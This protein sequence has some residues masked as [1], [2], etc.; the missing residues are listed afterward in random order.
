MCSWLKCVSV[1]GS[2]V[3]ELE[4]N[5]NNGNGGCTD[6]EDEDGEEPAIEMAGDEEETASVTSDKDDSVIIP[7]HEK[8]PASPSVFSVTPSD[9][10]NWKLL[11][12]KERMQ[13][14]QLWDL[15]QVSII[16]RSQFYLMFR[17]DPA[18]QVYMEVELRRLAWLQ[19]QLNAENTANV[20]C[21]GGDGERETN[22]A[23]R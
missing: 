7:L 17:G 11:F 13:I 10:N 14:A 21:E 4:S 19:E 23:A 6:Y 9:L 20:D 5:N 22:L 18:D 8:S 15:C 16:H 3:L 1:H 2:Q 12:H